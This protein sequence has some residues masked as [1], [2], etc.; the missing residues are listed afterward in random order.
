M[1]PKK[2]NR[3]PKETEGPFARHFANVIGKALRDEP[4]LNHG[5]EKTIMRWTGASGRSAKNWVSGMRGPS[6]PHLLLLA[7]QSDAVMEAILH[8]AGRGRLIPTVKLRNLQTA[9]QNVAL[10]IGRSDENTSELQ[11]LMRTLFAV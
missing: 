1:M 2:G 4:G 8:L 10:A 9:P 6:G 7:R 3:F 5:V 11:S